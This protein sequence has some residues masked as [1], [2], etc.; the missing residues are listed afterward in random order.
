MK[1]Y[2]TKA[3]Y[4]MY[5][6]FIWNHKNNNKK[7]VGFL[8]KLGANKLKTRVKN[9][10]KI[11]LMIWNFQSQMMMKMMKF[12]RKLNLYKRKKKEV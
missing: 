9:I 1:K 8:N 4:I 11:Y 6:K 2:K 3:L 10:S 5:R 12:R 7:Q